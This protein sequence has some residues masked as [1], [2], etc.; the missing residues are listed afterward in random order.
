MAISFPASTTVPVK[1]TGLQP[2]MDRV[3][4]LTDQV[5]HEWDPDDIHDLRVALRRCRTMA[6]TMAEVNPDPG[7]RKLKK[8]S[9]D[10]FHALGELRDVQVERQWLKKM[11]TPRDH[12]CVYLSKVLARKERSARGEARRSLESFDRKNWK[13]WSRKLADKSHF[14]PI[15]SVVFQRLALGRLNDTVELYQRARSG[16]SRVAWHRLRIGLKGF[17][18]VVENFLPQRYDAW[19][20]DL[21]RVQDLLGDVHDLDVLRGEFLRHKKDL[22]ASAEE[23]WKK[24]IDDERK[25]RLDEFRAKMTDRESL[26][27]VWRSAFGWGHTLQTASASPPKNT[28][29]SAS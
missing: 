3:L 26:F 2:W 21:K 8:T 15:E 9:R 25:I 27:L 13:K 7:W 16:R 4:E 18:Y 23:I 11:A 17:R 1:R 14:F 22:E 29:Y 28:A 20:D 19:R 6:E 12:A 5:R 24:K 10:V